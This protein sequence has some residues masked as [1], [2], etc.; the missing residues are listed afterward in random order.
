M[1]ATCVVLWGPVGGMGQRGMLGLM[2]EREDGSASWATWDD[3]AEA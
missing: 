3:E 2:V 1:G